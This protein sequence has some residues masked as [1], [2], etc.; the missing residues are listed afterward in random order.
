MIEWQEIKETVAQLPKQP[1]ADAVK[2]A[3][4]RRLIGGH[5]LIYKVVW[6]QLFDGGPKQRVAQ[7]TCTACGK[8]FYCEL[9]TREE[10]AGCRTC[11]KDTHRF[12]HPAF[13][14]TVGDFEDTLC[15]ACG[16]EAQTMHTQHFGGAMRYTIDSCNMIGLEKANGHLAV[17]AWS[18]ERFCD[19]AGKISHEVSLLDG[20]LLAGKRLYRIAGRYN[21]MGHYVK[22]DTPELRKRYA[23]YIGGFSAHRVLP[24]DQDIVCG[25]DADKTGIEN[26][27]ACESGTLYPAEYLQL[28]KKYPHVENLVRNGFEAF[29]VELISQNVNYYGLPMKKMQNAVNWKLAKPHEMLGVNK[30]D[31]ALVRGMDYSCYKVYS[32]YSPRDRKDVDSIKKI[33]KLDMLYVVQEMIELV[34]VTPARLFRFVNEIGYKNFSAR[35]YRDYLNMVKKVHGDV[36][37]ALKFPKNITEAHDRMLLQVKEK[38]NKELNEKIKA[39]FKKNQWMSYEDKDSG[40]CIRPAK[41]HLE[42]IKEGRVL[43]HCV[44]QYAQS[45]GNGTTCILFI[46]HIDSPDMPFY[47]LEYC[48]GTVVQNRGKKNCDRTKEV[49]EFEKKWLKFLKEGAGNN[50]KRNQ[51]SA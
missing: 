13:E 46:R 15:P 36:P 21:N 31:L 6:G 23:D 40:L 37:S 44:A 16:V 17:I 14:T 1:T 22:L 24:F 10:M 28:W 51:R 26:F 38:E 4:E 33:A 3:L 25:T 20:T 19:K 45:V 49:T 12:L 8:T 43:S 9:D 5:R 34:Q 2:I 48:N 32:T 7:I 18:V 35:E 47:T 42:I 41:T 39:Q 50:G 30:S 11:Y 29:V 27:L